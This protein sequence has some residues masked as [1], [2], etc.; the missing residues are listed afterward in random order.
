MDTRKLL[1]EG[2]VSKEEIEKITKQFK[3]TK[4]ID[5]I[6]GIIIISIILAIIVHKTHIESDRI[7]ERLKEEYYETIENNVE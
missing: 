2:N 4:Y 6:I 1:N 5:I 3:K 7:Y